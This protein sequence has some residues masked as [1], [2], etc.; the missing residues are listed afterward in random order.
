MDVLGEKEVDDLLA[1][2]LNAND[3]TDSE[4]DKLL[5]TS[6]MEAL[7]GNSGSNSLDLVNQINGSDF[8]TIDL[9]GFNDGNTTGGNQCKER[10]WKT[11]QKN[12]DNSGQPAGKTCNLSSTCKSSETQPTSNL[13]IDVT[14]QMSTDAKLFKSQLMLDTVFSPSTVRKHLTA[15]QIKKYVEILTKRL[16]VLQYLYRKKTGFTGHLLKSTTF[17]N[18][19]EEIL[20]IFHIENSPQSD[21]TLHDTPTTKHQEEF[22]EGSSTRTKKRRKKETTTRLQQSEKKKVLT[23]LEDNKWE[24]GNKHQRAENSEDDRRKDKNVR[25]SERLLNTKP[26]SELTE[27]SHEEEEDQCIRKPSNSILTEDDY[28]EVYA[29]K[30]E[31]EEPDG[32]GNATNDGELTVEKSLE[33][34]RR[35]RKKVQ[36]DRIRTVMN[37]VAQRSKLRQ[38]AGSTRSRKRLM[39]IKAFEGNK[40]RQF[41]LKK[42]SPTD[43]KSSKAKRTKK[44][45]TTVEQQYEEIHE[46]IEKNAIRKRKRK[47]SNEGSK[48]SCQWQV[49]SGHESSQSGIIKK[50]KLMP[51]NCDSDLLSMKWQAMVNE[52][53]D[54]MK[55]EGQDAILEVENNDNEE[56]VYE[57]DDDDS[58]W[59]TTYYKTDEDEIEYDNATAGNGKNIENEN[60][61]AEDGNSEERDNVVVVNNDSRNTEDDAM[62]QYIV[63]DED[64]M[65]PNSMDEDDETLNST[66]AKRSKKKELG[67]QTRRGRKVRCAFDRDYTVPP[68]VTID[69]YGTLR[70]PKDLMYFDYELDSRSYEAVTGWDRIDDFHYLFCL[71]VEPALSKSKSG[72]WVRFAKIMKALGSRRDNQMCA[73]HVNLNFDMSWY[74]VLQ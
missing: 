49:D 67:K 71:S 70:I 2:I 35:A 40:W 33:V 74:W 24:N 6:M 29:K 62:W 39:R 28:L 66:S 59:K 14:S 45:L 26:N 65:E 68:E 19:P 32:N 4:L 61:T 21:N 60:G 42:D 48:D 38:F 57:A 69:Y 25:Q 17:L 54:I 22:D 46:E 52:D 56:D 58:N 37:D 50:F 53:E 64:D 51:H 15:P 1:Q 8:P 27:K 13:T 47:A 18:P 16:N 11:D 31:I 9:T 12:E 34:I 41:L 55:K 43:C 44:K 36:M 73:D 3:V 7:Q 5:D 72:R 20:R 10:A 23:D 30:K 63:N